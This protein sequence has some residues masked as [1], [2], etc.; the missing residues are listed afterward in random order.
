VGDRPIAPTTVPEIGRTETLVPGGHPGFRLGSCGQFS[1]GMTEIGHEHFDREYWLAHCE[2]F[3]VRRG[4]RRLGFVQ[5]VLDGGRTLAVGGGL[6]GRR[7]VLV[8]VDGVS[9]IVP[10]AMRIW[11]SSA[12]PVEVPRAFTP[13]LTDERSAVGLSA[14]RHGDR[15][16]A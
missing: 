1:D 9:A 7:V 5:E 12:P 3:Q 8:P 16:A 14:R 10:R 4:R 13:L 2:G 11:L 6:L 15:V